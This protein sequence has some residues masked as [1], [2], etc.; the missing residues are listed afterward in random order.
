MPKPLLISLVIGTAI[1]V[2]IVYL[3]SLNWL[4]NVFFD[5]NIAKFLKKKLTGKD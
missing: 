3:W 2:L 5:I 4:I 1:Y